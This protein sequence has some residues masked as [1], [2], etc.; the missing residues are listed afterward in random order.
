MTTGAARPGGR[1]VATVF[2]ASALVACGGGE[3]AAT[4]PQ[5]TPT[6][7]ETAAVGP[8]CD[9]AVPPVS[10]EPDGSYPNAAHVDSQHVTGVEGEQ[11][12]LEV[13]SSED[14]PCVVAQWYA[15]RRGQPQSTRGESWTWSSE[16]TSDAHRTSTDLTVSSKELA[17]APP[18]SSGGTLEGRT[19][20]VSST[21][22]EPVE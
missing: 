1:V 22:S 6:A 17:S 4:D 11:I 5:L 10:E 9:L 18:L 7:A 2:L 3:P 16:S 15:A 13:R 14:D 19:I 21:L 8:G 20:I 12:S